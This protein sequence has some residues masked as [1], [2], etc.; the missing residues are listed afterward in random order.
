MG[1]FNFNFT[2]STNKGVTGETQPQIYITKKVLA[3]LEKGDMTQAQINT[4]HLAL[5]TYRGEVSFNIGEKKYTLNKTD[6]HS[7]WV[8]KQNPEQLAHFTE[9][10]NTLSEK[11]G[12]PTYVTIPEEKAIIQAKQ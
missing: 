11:P 12:E 9:L 8:T 2:D 6:T 5:P 3:I 7:F 10:F 1:K 4:K